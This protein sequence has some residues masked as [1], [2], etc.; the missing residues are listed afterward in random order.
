MGF[1]SWLFGKKKKKEDVPQTPGKGIEPVVKTPRAPE[2]VKE[3][4]VK[5]VPVEEA[6]VK[7]SPVAEASKVEEV[8]V[9][10]APV[11]EAPVQEAPV[12]EAPAEEAVEGTKKRTAILV[13]NNVLAMEDGTE[14]VAEGFRN[15]WVYMDNEAFQVAGLTARVAASKAGVYAQEITGVAK[16]VDSKGDDVTDRFRVTVKPGILTI[17]MNEA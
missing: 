11:Q 2:P 9:E 12:Q 10:K 1:F 15:T 16:V 13:G 8:Q 7:E 6:P 5:E 4:P 17:T 3:A 14:H